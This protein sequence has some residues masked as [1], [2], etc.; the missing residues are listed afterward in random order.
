MNILDILHK[1]VTERSLVF[2]A[3]N[4]EPEFLG[5]LTYCLLRLNSNKNIEAAE[6]NN[7]GEAG[8]CCNDD[9][10][11]ETELDLERSEDVTKH[12]VSPLTQYYIIFYTILFLFSAFFSLTVPRKVA[13]NQILG[14][15]GR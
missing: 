3:G 9:S 13:G 6:A 4:H 14:W 5:C 12:Q 8:S 15:P 2:G 7:S 11:A 10:E 1:I